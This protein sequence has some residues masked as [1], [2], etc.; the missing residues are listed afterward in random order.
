[1]LTASHSFLRVP[2]GVAP[3]VDAGAVLQ[4]L[5]EGCLTPKGEAGESMPGWAQHRSQGQELRLGALLWVQGLG[6]G[7]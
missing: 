7:M 1:M 4:V 6:R 3:G 5:Q 2:E